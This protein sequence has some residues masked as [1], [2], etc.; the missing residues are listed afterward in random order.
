[1]TASRSR[2]P[3][4]FVALVAASVL[5]A[6]VA[7]T[8]PPVTLPPSSSMDVLGP[9]PAFESSALPS[10]WIVEGEVDRGQMVVVERAG[11]PALMVV[12]GRHNFVAAKPTLASLL[13]TPYLSWAWNMEP[14]GSGA[15]PVRL[16]VGFNAGIPQNRPWKGQPPAAD[17][18][19]LP[20]HDRAIVITWGGSAL[21]RGAI[22]A[23]D[24]AR[25][26]Q[27]PAR[28]TARG[29]PENAR[30]WWLETVD[31]SDIYRRAWPADDPARV[32]IAFIGIAANAGN[33]PVPAYLSGIR[34]SR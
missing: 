8:R 7:C 23:P 32:Q 27:P 5:T 14:Q 11:V 29:G 25:L 16:V 6:V 26:P 22:V 2:R 21:Q 33:P 28:Y 31:L 15:H 3:S 34:L 4:F 10:D 18:Q 19:S 17:R 20:P 1:M 30:T 9:V 24:A 13:A 12:N